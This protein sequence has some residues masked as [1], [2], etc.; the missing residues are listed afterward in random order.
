M[1][2][3]T[4]NNPKG[5]ATYKQELQDTHKAPT[6]SVLPTLAV[7]GNA[8]QSPWHARWLL[9]HGAISSRQN[10]ADG[11]KVLSEAGV[12]SPLLIITYFLL[13][14][15]LN[16]PLSISTQP[17]YL[18]DL[19]STATPLYTSVSS[20]IVGK[21]SWPGHRPTEHYKS[22]RKIRRAGVF[23]GEPSSESWNLSS[24]R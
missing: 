16:S 7:T 9:Y 20:S 11:V 1:S 10:T 22:T 8:T 4:L 5:R 21:R 23:S 14:S 13:E 17:Q 12:K 6:N 15:N 19:G 2:Q 3:F 18:S 24:L